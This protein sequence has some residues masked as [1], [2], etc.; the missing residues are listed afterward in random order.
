MFDHEKRPA[1]IERHDAVPNRR[2]DF[3]AFGF[4]QRREQRSI[5]H[6]DVDLAEAPHGLRDQRFHC[7]LVADVGNRARNRI[8]AVLARKRLGDFLAIGNVGDHEPRAL[9]G[10]RPHVL[11]TDALGAAGDDGDAPVQSAHGFPPPFVLFSVLFSSCRRI[12]R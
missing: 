6:E 3:G 12:A 1:Q 7:R 11:H 5:V 2:I 4:P 9:G 10:E 8:G